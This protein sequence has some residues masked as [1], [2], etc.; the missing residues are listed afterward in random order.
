MM[1]QA[2]LPSCDFDDPRS[3]VSSFIAAMNEW[4]INALEA[5]RE[6][7]HS[8][9]PSAYQVSVLECMQEVFDTYCTKRPRPHG[10]LGSFQHPPEYDPASETVIDTSIDE[11]GRLALV[12][13][14]RTA[15]LGGGAFRY[16]L[17][18]TGGRW[19]INNLEC[20]IDGEWTAHIL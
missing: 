16:C 7:R 4:E 20:H 8:S 10:R 1:Q 2:D 12:I 15:F 18:R 5:Q 19:L 13:T 6:S 3:V 11:D 17:H 9:D 14:E